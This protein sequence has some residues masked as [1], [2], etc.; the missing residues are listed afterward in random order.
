MC[1]RAI[2]ACTSRLLQALPRLREL[3]P[4]APIVVRV[5]GCP[6]LASVRRDELLSWTV[7]LNDN[8]TQIKQPVQVK[9]PVQVMQTHTTQ[10]AH[11]LDAMTDK[12]IIRE[13]FTTNRLLAARVSALEAGTSFTQACGSGV[14]G[15]QTNSAQSTKLIKKPPYKGPAAHLGMVWYEWYADEPRLWSSN[16]PKKR[17]DARHNVAFMKLFVTNGFHLD[18][19]AVTYSDDVMALGQLAEKELLAFLASR[20][21]RSKGANSVLK[22]MRALHRSGQLDTAIH[23]YNDRVALG[24]VTDAAPREFHSI[25]SPTA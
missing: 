21:I 19:N 6:S 16:D 11:S 5:D 15:G 14:T 23:A 17:S 22:N 18:P 24:L 12:A 25:L 1:N 7:V 20:G 13:L 2:D 8:C 10:D 9:H 3:S 4:D